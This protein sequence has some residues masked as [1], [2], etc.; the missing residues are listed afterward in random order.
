[1][2]VDIAFGL[3]RG[4]CDENISLGLLRVYVR[5]WVCFMSLVPHV[6]QTMIGCSIGGMVLVVD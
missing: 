6:L 2:V 4:I 3:G 1:M 5:M